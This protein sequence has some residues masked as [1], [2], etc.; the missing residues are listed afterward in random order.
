MPQT[1]NWFVDATRP[2][3]HRLICFPYAGGGASAYLRLR[4][5]FPEIEL[6]GVQL[7]GRETRLREPLLRDARELLDQLSVHA[8]YFDER[9]YVLLGHS[10]GGRIAMLVAQMLIARCGRPPCALIVSAASAPRVRKTSEAS[11]DAEPAGPLSDEELLE[12]VRKFGGIPA[13][14]DSQPALREMVI[15]KLRAD[16][17]LLQSARRLATSPIP[18]PIFAFGGEGDPYVSPDSLERWS[19]FTQDK[20]ETRTFAGGHF[21]LFE[22]RSAALPFVAGAVA[23]AAS[24]GAGA[25]TRG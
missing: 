22:P 6:V 11:P 13:E 23:W 14:V 17:E 1:S 7:P 18:V 8:A 3:S 15:P 2:G 16:M 21:Y 12:D 24:R 4:P 9:P 5:H 19:H 10:L 25:R 20:F